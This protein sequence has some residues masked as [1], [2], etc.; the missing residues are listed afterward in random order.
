M[1]LR[2]FFILPLGI[3]CLVALISAIALLQ[4]ISGTRDTR[5]L[6]SILI[7]KTAPPLSLPVLEVSSFDKRTGPVLVNYFASW[8]APCRIEAPALALLSETIPIIG[9]AF[10]DKPQDTTK[11]LKQ[12]GN[13]FQ[14]VL[15]DETGVTARQW[16]AYGVPET[17]LLDTD[18]TVLLR[19]AG[20]IDKYILENVLKPAL[21][22]LK[23]QHRTANQ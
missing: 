5:Q 12:Y 3:F 21:K 23:Y 9:I 11:F 10:K 4:T 19:H 2:L 8:C 16:G 18:R 6:P 13:P 7:G 17:F 14:I 15:M 20:P 1:N 22:A